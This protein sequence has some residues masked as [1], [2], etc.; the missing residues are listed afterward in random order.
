MSYIAIPFLSKTTAIIRSFIELDTAQFACCLELALFV[1][2]KVKVSWLIFKQI[3]QTQILTYFSFFLNLIGLVIFCIFAL[4]LNS[5]YDVC[6][7]SQADT[8]RFTNLSYLLKYFVEVG[9]IWP[10]QAT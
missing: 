9:I 4:I 2:F 8:A 7:L 6:C 3:L 5:E 1:Y 10:G